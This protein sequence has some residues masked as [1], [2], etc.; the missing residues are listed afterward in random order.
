MINTFIALGVFFIIAGLTVYVWHSN[1]QAA[2][3]P[4]VSAP[5][6]PADDD[7]LIEV[8]PNNAIRVLSMCHSA[9][10]EIFDWAW[11]HVNK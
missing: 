3:R 2:K 11:K 7:L 8:L 6:L 1:K 5:M 10:H 9:S 4:Y